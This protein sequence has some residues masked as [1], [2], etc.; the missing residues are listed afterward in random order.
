MGW[1]IHGSLGLCM[2]LY[3]RVFRCSLQ[4]VRGKT[5][6]KQAG[7]DPFYKSC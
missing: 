4:M 6:T 5:S 7:V 2:I 1:G 3:E